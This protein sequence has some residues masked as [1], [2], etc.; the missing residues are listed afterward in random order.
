V[1]ELVAQLEEAR[2]Q[3]AACEDSYL[4]ARADLDNYRKRTERELEQRSRE[5]SDELLRAW[6]EVVDSIERALAFEAQP[7]A[8]DELRAVLEQ[9]QGLLARYGVTRLGEV[10]ERFD[11]ELH[12]AVAVV[13]EGETE[14]GTIAAVTRSGYAAGDRVIRPPLV[15]VAGRP[16]EA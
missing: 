15:A 4:R 8:A 7:H 12:E 3:L 2:S 13:P 14:P 1:D 6:L 11:P 5:R 9:M 16:D 10:G